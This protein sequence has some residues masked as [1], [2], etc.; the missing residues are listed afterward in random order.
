[1]YTFIENNIPPNY[2]YYRIRYYSLYYAHGCCFDEIN[3]QTPP[4]SIC[5]PQTVASHLTWQGIPQ[6]DTRNE[7]ITGTLTLCSAGTPN[8]YTAATDASGSFTVTTDLPRG[9]YDWWFKGPRWLA[10]SGTAGPPGELGT[11]RA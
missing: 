3:G 10:T 11:Q 4:T 2:T 8:S 5:S 1:T 9:T 6:S 7:G